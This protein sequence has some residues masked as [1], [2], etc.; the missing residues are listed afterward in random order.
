[1]VY[2]DSRPAPGAAPI[3]PNL[4]PENIQVTWIKDLNG[5]PSAVNVTIVNYSLAAVFSSFTFDHRPF[6]EF[7]YIGRYAPAESE[8]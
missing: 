1:M 8:P 4:K 7:P 6:A 3:A 2:G 5:A